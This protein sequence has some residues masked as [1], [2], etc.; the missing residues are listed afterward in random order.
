MLWA[1]QIIDKEENKY[2]GNEQ[3]GHKNQ[4]SACD[5]ESEMATCYIT[6]SV[7]W[8]KLMDNIG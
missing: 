7:V 2:I 3:R 4:A 8:C 1:P 5:F 6:Y